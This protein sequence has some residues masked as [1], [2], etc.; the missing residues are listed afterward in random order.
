MKAIS[1]PVGLQAGFVS[2]PGEWVRRRR[3]PPP[4]SATKISL[5]PST[6]RVKAIRV[7]SGEKSGEALNEPSVTTGVLLPLAS[8]RR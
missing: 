5:L 1:R 3:L 4:R 6:D 8:Y 7:P 2:M